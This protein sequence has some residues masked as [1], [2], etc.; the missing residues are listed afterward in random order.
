MAINRCV[1]DK[2]IE[3]RSAVYSNYDGMIALV[4]NDDKIYLGKKENYHFNLKDDEPAYYDNKDNSLLWISN[5]LNMFYFLYSS[6]WVV[7]QKAMLNHGF[8][9]KD[10]YEFNEL[11]K[12][13]S[14]KYNKRCEIKFKNVPFKSPEELLKEVDL[15]KYVGKRINAYEDIYQFSTGKKIYTRGKCIGI[16]LGYDDEKVDFFQYRN[17]EGYKFYSID[18]NNCKEWLFEGSY[19]INYNSLSSEEKF[20]LEKYNQ[21]KNISKENENLEIQI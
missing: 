17:P 8:S 13:L 19:K 11:Q 2:R 20:E 1:S 6:G 9:M 21:E 14:C 12:E 10:Y 4:D 15:N 7:S 16:I 3:I 5:N 18:I